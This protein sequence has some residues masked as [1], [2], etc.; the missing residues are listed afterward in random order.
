MKK[1]GIWTVVVLLCVVMAVSP[2]VATTDD[3]IIG[4][5]RGIMVM[6]H[7]ST[8]VGV[9]IVNNTLLNIWE[10][11][12]EYDRSD[13]YRIGYDLE[14]MAT[15]ADAIVHEYPDR[16]ETVM[17]SVGV[18]EDH[19]PIVWAALVGIPIEEYRFFFG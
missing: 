14:Y 18:S 7:P 5:A 4:F 1:L 6:D 17:L 10:V 3:E 16:F 13:L 19:G 9:E 11:H 15:V 2:C 12:D 8:P